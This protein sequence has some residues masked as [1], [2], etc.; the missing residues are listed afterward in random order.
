M[1]RTLSLLFLVFFFISS[2]SAFAHQHCQMETASQR[3]APAIAPTIGPTDNSPMPANAQSWDAEIYLVNF[4]KDQE[5]KVTRAIKLMKKVIASRE[6]R[7]RVINHTYNGHKTFVDNLGLTNEQIYQRVL[8]G[9]ER[10]LP[11]KNNMMDVELELYFQNTTTIGYTYPNTMRIWMNTKY[12]NTYTPV[13]VSGNLF[14]EWMHKLGFDH[15]STWSPARDF[16]VPY[17]LGYLMQELTAK[18]HR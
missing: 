8:D 17:A 6:F 13:G 16:S 11:K 4:D 14:H 7:D 12:F 18:Y 15:A 10:L 9:A 1:T 3:R 2:F 5:A